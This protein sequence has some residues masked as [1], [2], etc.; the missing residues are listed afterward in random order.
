MLGLTF[1]KTIGGYS[2]RFEKVVLESND[3]LFFITS[4]DIDG[5]FFM[6][7]H[8]NGKWLILYHNL[9]NKDFLQLEHEFSE[10]LGERGY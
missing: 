9:V 7:K 8:N 6:Y 5:S 10:A 1:K 3:P 4:I 2:F